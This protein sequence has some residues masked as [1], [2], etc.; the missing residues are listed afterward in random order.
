MGQLASHGP[1]DSKTLPS[2]TPDTVGI[3]SRFRIQR[4]GEMADSLITVAEN[5]DCL[6]SFVAARGFGTEFWSAAFPFPSSP[7]DCLMFS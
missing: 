6:A 2:E 7:R 5:Q 1:Q 4:A 3:R